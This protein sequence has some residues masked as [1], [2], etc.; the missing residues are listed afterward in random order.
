VWFFLY[1]QVTVLVSAAP[2]TQA[3]I[4]TA[5]INPTVR[6]VLARDYQIDVTVTPHP[7][8][9][10]TRLARRVSG[11]ASNWEELA[12]FNEADETL[13]THKAIRVPYALLRPELQ[14]DIIKTL[15]PQ[16]QRSRR[17]GTSSSARAASKANRSGTSRSGSPAPAPTTRSYAR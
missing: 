16:D 1:F 4:A 3:P 5:Q 13:K 9:A 8:D 7:G 11:D 10:W 14:R 6:A 17:L 12:A 2:A 15:F